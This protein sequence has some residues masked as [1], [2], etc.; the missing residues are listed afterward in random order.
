MCRRITIAYFLSVGSIF[1]GVIVLPVYT[2]SSHFDLGEHAADLL[3]IDKHVI[4]PFKRDFWWL[5][6]NI[7]GRTR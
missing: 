3:V 5:L 7:F 4:N 6:I 2:S 1:F